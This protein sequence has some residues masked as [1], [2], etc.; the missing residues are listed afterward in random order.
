M[1]EKIRDAV[2]TVIAIGAG[3]T[4]AIGCWIFLPRG[5]KK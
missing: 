5:P 2:M 4:L 3:V 1:R